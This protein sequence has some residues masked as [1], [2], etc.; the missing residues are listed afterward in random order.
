MDW[1]AEIFIQGLW[2][3]FGEVAY[4]KWGWVGAI[5]VFLAPIVLIG[6]LLW[7]LLG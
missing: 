7:A 5:S 3:G 6:L 1:I 4:H 2:E